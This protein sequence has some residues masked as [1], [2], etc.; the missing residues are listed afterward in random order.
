METNIMSDAPL[1][2]SPGLEGI[3]AGETTI[4]EVNS[5]KSSLRYRGILAPDLAKYGP[6]E[7]T[8]YL[9]LHEK[10][11]TKLEL[12]QFKKELAK[13]RDVPQEVY[14]VLKQLPKKMHLMDYLRTGYSALAGFDPDYS[15]HDHEANLRKA[16]RIIA[17]ASTLVANTYRIREGLE[18]IAPNLNLSIAG[19]FLYILHGGSEQSEPFEKALDSSL[20]L[21]ADHGYN[22]STFAA[23]VTVATLSDIYSGIVTGIGTLKGPLHGGANEEAM[24]M[25]LE[26]GDKEKAHEWI[27]DALDTKKKIMGFGHREYKHGDPRARYMKVLAREIG[28]SINDTQWCDAADI[29]EE[30]MDKQ[31]N[32]YPNVDFPTAYAYY[33][34]SIPIEMYTPLFVL[35]RVV[36]WSAHIMEQ[37]EH[38]RLIRPKCLYTGPEDVPYTPIEKR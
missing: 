17:K 26:I 13:E 14:N 19:N 18:P 15:N 3:I 37:L 33:M 11:P 10:L 8:C 36:G 34:M 30:V 32:I 12:D 5:D 9:L 27:Q 16:V 35:A 24:K 2:Y 21:Y 20:T 1:N 7:E 28:E 25:L 23:H 22:A 38:N 6:Y 4:S 29:I 31:K